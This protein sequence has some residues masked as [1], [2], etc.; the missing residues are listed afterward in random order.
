[1]SACQSTGASE[2]LVWT[3]AFRV[4]HDTIDKDHQKLFALVNRLAEAVAAGGDEAVL[5]EVVR[6]LLDYTVYHF[7]REEVLM[8]RYH[9]PQFLAHKRMHDDFVREIST[10]RDRLIGRSGEGA[11][12]ASLLAFLR[13]W[14]TNHILKTDKEVGAYIASHPA[15]G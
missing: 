14:L 8:R 2:T 6:E 1:M 10:V 3:D 13:D 5:R 15:G 12:S 7:G 11:V 4:G 9:Y